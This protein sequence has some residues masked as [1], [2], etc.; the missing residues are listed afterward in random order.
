M[1]RRPCPACDRDN[2]DEP[3]SRYSRDD[4]QIKDCPDCDFVYLENPPAY[5][6]LKVEFA[7]EKTSEKERVERKAAEPAKQVVSDAAKTA[8]KRLLKRDK[9]PKLIA[10][11]FQP[12]RVL[13]IGCATGGILKRLPPE[14]TPFGIEISKKLAKK[15]NKNLA[16]R[17]GEVVHADALSGAS[18]FPDAHF[19]GIIMSAFL[20]HE[21]N[22]KP[23][24]EQCRRILTTGGAAIIKVPNYDSLLRHFRGARWCGFRYPDHVN[25]FTPSTLAKM[26]LDAGLEIARFGLPDRFPL[27]DN[28]WLVAGVPQ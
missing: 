5:E 8:R 2:A 15:G 10:R 18:A 27:S 16:A 28:M 23:L 22:P 25:Y 1:P 3:P 4:W 9:L 6:A 13:D 12:G 14:F 7:W 24:L 17:G 20:E 11:H 19:T 21:V 26:V